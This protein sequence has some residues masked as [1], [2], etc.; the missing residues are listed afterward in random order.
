MTTEQENEVLKYLVNALLS[1]SNGVLIISKEEVMATYA[2]RFKY[3]LSPD[4]A[5]M[6]EA[7]E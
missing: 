4:G 2:N 3:E 6:V 5:I 1:R 7:V